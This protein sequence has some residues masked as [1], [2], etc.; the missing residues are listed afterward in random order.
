MKVQFVVV[1]VII[2]YRIGLA[3]SGRRV[4]PLY[5]ALQIAEQTGRDRSVQCR[6]ELGEVGLSSEHEDDQVSSPDQLKVHAV[7]Q[8]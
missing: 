4:V 2:A 6:G 3:S 1:I 8:L 7:K 5:M